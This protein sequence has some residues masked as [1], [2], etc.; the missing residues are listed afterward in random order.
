MNLYAS[1][2]A[3]AQ[4]CR[5]LLRPIMR[6][7]RDLPDRVPLEA[8]HQCFDQ[9]LPADREQRFWHIVCEGPQA[10]TKTARHYAWG[11]GQ[12]P[13]PDDLVHVCYATD[14]SIVAG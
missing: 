7:D 2:L 8:F 6:R 13:R 1:V 5:D 9:G 10:R 11:D 14:L 12:C 4:L 3:V